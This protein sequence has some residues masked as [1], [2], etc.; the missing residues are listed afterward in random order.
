MRSGRIKAMAKNRRGSNPAL[1]EDFRYLIKQHGG[2]LAKGR[3]L[4][5][6]RVPRQRASH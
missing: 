5:V 6:L 1:K 2:M 4:G 3:L